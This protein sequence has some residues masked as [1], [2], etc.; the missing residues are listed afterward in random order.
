MYRVRQAATAV[1]AVSLG[2]IQTGWL[3][4]DLEEATARNTPLSRFGRPADTAV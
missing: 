1:N 4:P 3:D 2:P